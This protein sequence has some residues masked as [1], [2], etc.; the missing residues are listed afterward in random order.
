MNSTI[1]IGFDTDIGGSNQN[2]DDMFLWNDSENAICVIAV[3]DG[4]G[5]EFGKNIEREL[6]VPF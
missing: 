2:Q 3:F 1:Q 5:R 4:H 6:V